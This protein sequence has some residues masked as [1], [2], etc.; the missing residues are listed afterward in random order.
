MSKRKTTLR[1]SHPELASQ[2]DTKKNQSGSTDTVTSG[3]HK[4]VW[5]VCDKG[6]SWEAS[7]KNRAVKGSGCPYCSGRKATA[8]TSIKVTF[9]ELY[10]AMIRYG[11]QK[12]NP[13]AVKKTARAKVMLKCDHGHI[14]Q[15]TPHKYSNWSGG[16]LCPYCG[17][18][19]LLIG[20][21]DL[22][23]LYPDVAALWDSEKNGKQ[24]SEVIVKS[25]RHKEKL[26][27]VCPEGHTW[28][29]HVSQVVKHPGCPVCKGQEIVVGYNDLSITRPDLYAE[30][31]DSYKNEES[32]SKI[33]P[34]SNVKLLW[35]CPKG[36][37][38]YEMLVSKRADGAGCPVCAGN[39]LHVGVNDL[40]SQRPDV[41]SQWDYNKN[42]LLPNQVSVGTI[43]KVWWTCDNGHS[44]EASVSKRTSG[45]GC[46]YC[47]NKRVLPGFNDLATIRPDIAARWHP[48]K[49][50]DKTPEMFTF[51][52]GFVAWWRCSK[53]HE[54]QSD[55]DH[56]SGG[57]SCPKCSHNVSSGE[58]EVYEFVRS[59]LP[60]DIEIIQSDRSVISPKELDI[61]I[62]DKKIAI[63]YNGLYWHSEKMGKP[64]SYHYDK[65][66]ACSEKGIQLITIW[67]DEWRDKQD[68]VKS[69]L[70]HKLGMSS[71]EKVYARKT[72]VSLVDNNTAQEFLNAYHIQ[73][74]VT[75]SAYYGLFA[76]N[77]PVAVSVWRKNK[78]ILYLDR[79][80]TKCQVVGG[81]GKM[82]K[83][84]KQYAQAHGLSKIV[85]FS[86]NSVS[87][88]SLYET[89][90]FVID[91]CLSPD[92]RY[93]VG[94]DVPV[95][96]HKFGYRK[97]RFKNDPGLI[98]RSDMT[99]QELALAN[100]LPRVYDCGKKRW[101]LD[102]S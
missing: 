78:D 46:P 26:H 52:S 100:D 2:W 56:Q 44:Y 15:S 32:L 63:E 23:T 77:D 87:D 12:A 84:G 71:G 24:A 59:I 9:P 76:G 29:N 58:Q 69:M 47:A 74:A 5:W 101:V 57:C 65:W 67:E 79:Y 55:I 83:A 73:G 54:W 72:D 35:N 61:Y 38:S 99:E 49:N 11:K 97:S 93:V 36:H 34:H 27:W 43:K 70:T 60:S 62:P 14:W 19:E 66:S 28:T 17:N 53:G 75:G 18:R 16:C 92:Y 89:L 13:E 4:K 40:Q 94:V 80:A 8:E 3:S 96:C 22:E 21:N 48:T 30:L 64:K 90:G 6:H 25:D 1:E 50:G 102:V 81:M 7:V 10:E 42:T 39:A 68:V 20:F 31:D 85:T 95:R 88:G 33:F 41:L 45:S 37:G 98:Y 86:D 82:L 91:K 51:R